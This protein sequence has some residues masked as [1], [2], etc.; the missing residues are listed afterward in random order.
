MTRERSESIDSES[1]WGEEFGEN[2]N[3]NYNIGDEIVD[4][5]RS[6]SN[7]HNISNSNS[8]CYNFK[9]VFISF[10]CHVRSELSLAVNHIKLYSNF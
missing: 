4:E 8:C 5:R 6:D 3:P 9:K 1:T 10:G 2:N 7:S